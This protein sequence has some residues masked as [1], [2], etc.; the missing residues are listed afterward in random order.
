MIRFNLNNVLK[1]LFLTIFLQFG[2]TGVAQYSLP[3]VDSINATDYSKREIKEILLALGTSDQI[4]GLVRQS[5]WNEFYS[6]TG[7]VIAVPGIVVGVL[8]TLVALG[9]DMGY[10]PVALGGF[11]I[12]A[13]GIAMGVSKNKRAKQNLEEAVHLYNQ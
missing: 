7:Y 5:E 8:G 2:F 3:V 6:A 12:G 13:L 11:G 9:Y 10:L 4:K 1:T